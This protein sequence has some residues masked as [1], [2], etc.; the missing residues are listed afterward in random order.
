MTRMR[1]LSS[2]DLRSMGISAP[3]SAAKQA[4]R[5]DAA[6]I[7]TQGKPLSGAVKAPAYEVSDVF[8]F[9]SYFDDTL[10]ERAL[11]RQSPNEPIVA[12]T[13]SDPVQT[14]GYGLAL[15]PSSETPVAVQFDTGAQQGQSPTYRLKP[16]EVVR[17]EGKADGRPGFFTGFKWGLPFGWLG[18]GSA[19][20]VVLRSPDAEVRWATDHNEIVYH[21]IRLPIWDPTDVAFPAAAGLYTGPI[22]WPQRFPWPFAQF[23]TSSL[24]QRGQP[25]LAVMPTRTALSLRLATVTLAA[26][27]ADG[28]FRMYWVGADVWAQSGPNASGVGTISLADVRATDQIWGTWVQ[29]AGAPAPFNSAYQTLLLTGEA[30]RYA[31]NAGALLMASLDPQL[32]GEFVDIVRYGRL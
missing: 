21:R 25:G 27:P 13:L 14:A 8:S 7:A 31:A 22:N 19:T 28:V 24:T 20:L 18:G 9:Q 30:E 6:R 16:G 2:A 10:M 4:E 12:S 17:P 5:V 15:T 23:G 1:P 26:A 11:F 3:G 29:Q 32:Q